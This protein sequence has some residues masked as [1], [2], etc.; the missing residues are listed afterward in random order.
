[1]SDQTLRD[2]AKEEAEKLLDLE[3]KR[4]ESVE[5]KSLIKDDQSANAQESAAKQSF[6]NELKSHPELLITTAGSS[7]D[8][9]TITAYLDTISTDGIVGSGFPSAADAIAAD[10]SGQRSIE[11]GLKME[12][13]KQIAW[14]ELLWRAHKLGADGIIGIRYDVYMPFTGI[15]GASVTGTAVK[16]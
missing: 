5:G 13:A 4:D 3:D 2:R 7:F 12:R 10:L 15:F 9:L 14:D 11:L 6:L 8:G 16:F 1:M